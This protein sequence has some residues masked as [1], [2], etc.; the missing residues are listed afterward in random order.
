MQDR[1]H[2]KQKTVSG[3]GFIAVLRLAALDASFRN[4]LLLHRAK[5]AIERG[6]RL[7]DAESDMLRDVSVR[8][9]EMTIR[10]MEAMALHRDEEKRILAT[11]GSRLYG[12][13]RADMIERNSSAPDGLGLNHN[14]D[15]LASSEPGEKP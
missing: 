15:G 1:Y 6:I 5:A 2:K 11:K 9:L 14:I 7:T 12:G 8:V 3:H 4:S 10:S 13:C